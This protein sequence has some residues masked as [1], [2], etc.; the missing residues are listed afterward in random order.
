MLTLFR[1]NRKVEPLADYEI[2]RRLGSG[3]FATVYCVRSKKTRQE[4]ACKV[5]K[6]QPCE[7]CFFT[8]M[9]L[10]WLDTA[11][12]CDNMGDTLESLRHRLAFMKRFST[13]HAHENVMKVLD[14]II[15]EPEFYIFVEM[16]HGKDL[17]THVA[18]SPEGRLPELDAR[19]VARALTSAVAH[20]HKHGI[21]HRDIKAENVLHRTGSFISEP[22]LT[23]FGLSVIEAQRETRYQGV[24]GSIGYMAA[25][26]VLGR[27]WGML[28]DEFALGVTIYECLTGVRALYSLL[29][30]LDLNE[31]VQRSP[32][33]A[34]NAAG[35]VQEI[36]A[37]KR[38]PFPRRYWSDISMEAKDF[39]LGLCR[40]DADTRLTSE[41]ALVHPWLIDSPLASTAQEETI[42]EE[43]ETSTARLAPS[44]RIV[45][46]TAEPRYSQVAVKQL[47]KDLGPFSLDSPL[48]KVD[49]SGDQ[50]FAEALPV[51]V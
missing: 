35:Y 1:G 34:N 18:Q 8:L 5:T 38:L 43:E 24:A 47:V 2:L 29:M 7:P 48:L 6:T 19:R 27:E 12:D 37:S 17:Y 4:L 23:D 28:V 21:I 30:D 50:Y 41:D 32:F 15:A 9:M 40:I 26:I 44:T 22:I 42:D 10:E 20:M 14:G 11:T 49:M 46:T 25:E 45:L 16:I 51:L 33:L 36:A 31:D 3:G 13:Q 39:V